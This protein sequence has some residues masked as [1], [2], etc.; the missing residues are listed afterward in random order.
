M[1]DGWSKAVEGREGGELPY[2]INGFGLGELMEVEIA[3]SSSFSS[4]AS[5]IELGKKSKGFEGSG[6]TRLIDYPFIK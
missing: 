5:L 4:L 3:N 1:D 6:R 2:N